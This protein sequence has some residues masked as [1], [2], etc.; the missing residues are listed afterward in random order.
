MK[1]QRLLLLFCA[2][3][4]LDWFV[5][6]VANKPYEIK[7]SMHRATKQQKEIERKVDHD[8]ISQKK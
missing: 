3:A 7:A 6:R 2:C 1:N 8:K 4:L 5:A